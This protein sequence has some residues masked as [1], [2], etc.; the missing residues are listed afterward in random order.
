MNDC[1]SLPCQNG[2]FCDSSG[3]GYFC[4][5]HQ[6]SA[7]FQ[8]FFFKIIYFS[9]RLFNDSSPVSLCDVFANLVPMM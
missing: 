3:K 5:L 9:S 4:L 2:G 6:K 8:D 7:D 1:N